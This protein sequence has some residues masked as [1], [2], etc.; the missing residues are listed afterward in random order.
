MKDEGEPITDDEFLLRRVHRDRFYPVLSPNVFEPR[1][2]GQD[3]DTDGI[4]LYREACLADPDDILA[5][6]P[7]DKRQNTGLVRVPVSL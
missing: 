2:R 6:I 1:I 4:S 3:I 7:A 5:A